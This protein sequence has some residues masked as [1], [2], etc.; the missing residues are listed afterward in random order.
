M[1]K[2]K[3]TSKLPNELNEN[4]GSN[5]MMD[6]FWH[7]MEYGNGLRENPPADP[8]PQPSTSGMAQLPDGILLALED[9]LE[10]QTQDEEGA[11]DLARLGLVASTVDPDVDRSDAGIVDH[12]W[13]G[14]AYQDPS[15]LPNQP[16]D[17]GIPELQS[18]WGNRTDGIQRID[19]R[20]RGEVAYEDAMQAE[21][22]DDT[23]HRDKLARL[24]QSAM[25]K[26]AGGEPFD[27]LKR[28]LASQVNLR[29]A[30]AMQKAVGALEA[31]HGLVGNVYV[32]AAAYPGLHRGRWSDAFR[33]AAKG[34]RYL[35]AA[36]GEDCASCA[37]VTGLVLVDNPNRI[38]WND[39]WD[40]YAPRLESG[41]RLDRTAT[42]IDKRVALR[43]AFLT[44][45]RAPNL[46]VETA[47]VRHTMPVDTVSAKEARAAVA[48]FQPPQRVVLDLVRRWE[49]GSAERVVKKLGQMVASRLLTAEEADALVSS[50]ASPAEILRTAAKLCLVVK[51]ARYS[52][53]SPVVQGKK[54]TREGAWEE[55][56]RA[57][58][59]EAAEEEVRQ[60]VASDR[61]DQ[62][63]RLIKKAIEGGLKGRRLAAMIRDTLSREEA[64]EASLKLSPI[65][66]KTGA[67]NPKAPERRRYSDVKLTRHV[68]SKVE[69]DPPA[70]EMR[71]AARWVRQQMSEGFAGRDLDDLVSLRLDSRVASSRQVASVREQ[72]EGLA[73]HLYVDAGAYASKDGT[74]G[75][76]EGALRHRANGIK[77]LLAMKRCDGCVFKNA[78]GV[79]QK[80]NKQ[81]VD[82]VDQNNGDLEEFRRRMLA[83]HSA[84]DAEETASAFSGNDVR[85]ALNPNPVDEFGLHNAA[86][87]HVENEDPHHSSIDHIFF[88]GFEV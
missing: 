34:C 85:A 19:L 59:R 63:V 72:H 9:E 12:S 17:N 27:R 26:S 28:H 54:V 64:L 66:K 48:A 24:L 37:A 41:G 5:Y 32:R 67:L 55:L 84:S 52:G 83:S 11:M 78:D 35:V 69:I 50:K 77:L 68:A 8:I 29:E 4:W 31:E 86:L 25:R 58:V 74:A 15:R 42:V 53:G 76:D 71:R 44:E 40:H 51:T 82:E 70:T 38:D 62:K 33:K 61:L 43:K 81:I 65:L 56:R 36:P 3:A 14:E 2:K 21:E 47:K 46:H 39:A 13:L 60:R 45:G 6:G 16:V 79:C 80:Y 57:E 73:G 88:G 18:A 87:D 49:R 7:D 1:S 75:C 10:V 30:R 23:L 22:D 20:D